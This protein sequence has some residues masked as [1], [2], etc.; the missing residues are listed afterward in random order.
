LSHMVP[1]QNWGGIGTFQLRGMPRVDPSQ[2]PTAELRSVT[3]GYFDALGIPLRAGRTLTEEDAL[4]VPGPILINETLAKR[5]FPGEDA[6]GRSM[7]RG[8]IVG[9]VGD[10]RQV[11]LMGAAPAA[12]YFPLN[13]NAGIASD[14]GMSLIVRTH[15][16]PEAAVDAVRM[17]V[18]GVNQNL[19]I[20]N[21]K[22]MDQVIDDS[23][24]QLNLYR[25]LIGLFALL[26]L[27]LAAIGLYGVISYNAA[28]RRREFA[29]RLAIGCE[30]TR[31]IR[32]VLGRAVRL[33][34]AGIV[35][36][37]AAAL[38]TV[39][40]LRLLQLGLEA[41]PATLGG[42]AALLMA[43][44]LCACAIPAIRVAGVNP[45]TALRHD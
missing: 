30:G 4:R 29:V 20:F 22:T 8:T 15:G 41:V 26:T 12:I 38:A 44:A 14:I 24:W 32:L 28:T 36:G 10:V 34:G 37:L 45:V 5:H 40:L 17:A 1:L 9:I 33:T 6:I 39:P 19:A 16:P 35:L 11:A 43:L 25:Q 21:V 27:V 7:D 2:L 23:L 42:V 31:L 18:R 3:P 13:Q